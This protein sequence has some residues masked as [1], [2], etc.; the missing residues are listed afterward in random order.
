MRSFPPYMVAN[1]LKILMPVGMPT[2]MV[3][4]AKKVLPMEVITTANMRGAHTLRLIKPMAMVAPI[5]AGRP[6]IGL[7]E[8]T[9]ITS[10]MQAKPGKTRM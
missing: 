5:M 2:N 10:E 9:G 3:D 8:N 4:A 7:R 1:Q 6:K